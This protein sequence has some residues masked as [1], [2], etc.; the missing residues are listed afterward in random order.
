MSEKFT[1]VRNG[2]V[3]VIA[4]THIPVRACHLPP[5]IF[6]HFEGASMIIHA[7][8]LVE[9]N[10]VT[11]LEAIAPVLAVS[12][13]MDPLSLYHKFG[14]KNIVSING[15]KIGVV[16][17]KGR[18]DFTKEWVCQMF[19]PKYYDGVVF[20]HLHRPIIE[21]R[22]SYTLFNPGSPT[23]PRGSSPSCGRLWEEN[24]K[25]ITEIISIRD[26]VKG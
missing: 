24:G 19:S 11:E 2:W 17:G 5:E 14:G 18:G 10:V 13:N 6:Q 8:D 22:N 7:G 3:G 4:D 15:L 20:G 9:E 12:G 16:H 23:N 21:K 1:K 26:G 25:L